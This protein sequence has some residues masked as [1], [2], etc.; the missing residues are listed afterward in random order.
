MGR[1]GFEYKYDRMSV[2]YHLAGSLATQAEQSAFWNQE[3]R[4]VVTGGY[5]VNIINGRQRFQVVMH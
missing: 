1:V 2:L 3:G 4:K 5:S